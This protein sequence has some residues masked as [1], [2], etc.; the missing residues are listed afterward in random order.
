MSSWPVERDAIYGCELWRGP[1]SPN[2]YPVLHDGG[3]KSAHRVAYERACGLIP[4]DLVL[5]HL[6]RRRDCVNPLHLEAVTRHENELRKSWAYRC[7]RTRCARGHDLATALV[8]PEMG[9]LC[10]HCHARAR[11]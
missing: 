7:R 6:C 8:T 1:R 3:R 9:R 2:G 10:R 5:D 11:V 4:A